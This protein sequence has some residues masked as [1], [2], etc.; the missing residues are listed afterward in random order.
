LIGVID[1]DCRL[2]LMR[3]GVRIVGGETD[4]EPVDLG[5]HHV[6]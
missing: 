5:D 3:A 2:G 6:P 4:N 1:Y